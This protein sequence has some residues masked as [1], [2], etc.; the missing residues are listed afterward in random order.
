VA[1]HGHKELEPAE[2]RM[3]GTKADKLGTYCLI[4]AAVGIIASLILAPM[5]IGGFQRLAHAWLTNLGFFLTIAVGGLA[6]V[7][8]TTLFRAGWCVVVRRVP[9]VLGTTTGV[10]GVLFIPLLV[11][12]VLGTGTL[13]DW[14][15]PY[16]DKGYGGHAAAEIEPDV[17]AAEYE[18]VLAAEEAEHDHADHAGD[19]HAAATG[20]A[21]HAD[22][23][24][25]GDGL[26]YYAAKKRPYLNP[27]FFTVRVIAFFALWFWMAS[28]FWGRSVEQDET[29]EGN[30]TLRMQVRAP[31]KVLLFAMVTTFGFFDL[32][33]SLSPDWYST[34][35][36]VYLFSGAFLSCLCVMVLVYA[37]LQRAGYIPT[38]VTIE[39]Y[40]D[41]GKLMFAFVF[42]WTYVAFSQYMLY[43]Y[44]T[45]PEEIFW[46]ADRGASAVDNQLNGWTWVSL[47][48]LLGHF[49]IPFAG[50]LSRHVKRNLVALQ[51]WA[52][53]LLVFHWI[54]LYWV[55]MP[56][57]GLDNQAVL[58]A[59]D[60]S[61]HVKVLFGPIE[62]TTFLGIGGVVGWVAL[63]KLG[64]HS[65]I[66]AKDPRLK[67]S[68]AFE[69]L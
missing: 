46:Y 58:D 11:T 50:L 5:S 27:L 35:F 33:M 47:A 57:I 68:L 22:H 15:V 41:M 12:V 24:D 44:A 43:A 65:L 3:L 2:L 38:S 21:A 60:A 10:L 28:W 61:G 19:A 53:W 37:A 13:Y 48:L 69:N 40:H 29:G 36:G 66:P 31:L 8:L 9:E 63:T 23:A 45:I 20:D 62:I 25:H 49:A 17:A 32:F 16:E 6:F 7:L 54:D 26:S 30:L 52:V 51:F 18:I 1:G 42:F 56:Q 67:E 64:K 55:I 4:V 59:I 34:M 14:A 39:H